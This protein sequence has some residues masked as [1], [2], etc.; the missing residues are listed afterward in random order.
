MTLPEAA[1]VDF[2]DDHILGNKKIP[3]L[4][5]L[6]ERLGCSLEEALDIFTA[7]YETLRGERPDDFV[8]GPDEY[9]AGFIS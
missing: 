3:G 8:C 7:R 1:S 9:W 5:A 6:R 2:A 4:I